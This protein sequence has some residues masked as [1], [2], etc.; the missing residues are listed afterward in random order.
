MDYNTLSK[1]VIEAV[2]W[3]TQKEDESFGGEILAERLSNSLVEAGIDIE[4][5]LGFAAWYGEP[6]DVVMDIVLAFVEDD[7]MSDDEDPAI[8]RIQSDLYVAL[9][10]NAH[11]EESHPDFWTKAMSAF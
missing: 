9:Q 1:E 3:A 4:S 6:D 7:G 2:K 5:R 11:L 10:E 8:S